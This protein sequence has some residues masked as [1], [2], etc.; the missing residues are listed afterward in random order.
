[1]EEKTVKY[2]FGILYS[3]P[4]NNIKLDIKNN[5][6]VVSY[7]NIS[8]IICNT[9]EVIIPD[10]A[11]KK[12]VAQLLL[13]HQ[14]VLEEIMQLGFTVLPMKLA[15]Y[16][17]SKDKI[18]ELLKNSYDF[19]NNL[20]KEVKDKI[21][22]DIIGSWADFPN[23]LKMIGENPKVIET[24]NRIISKKEGVT[25]ADQQEIG[26]LISKLVKNFNEEKANEC[27]KYLKPYC[28]QTK[29]HDVMNDQMIFNTAFLVEK[30]KINS[31]DNAI[32]EL[33]SKL[34]SSINF[35]YVGPL[36][37]YSFYTIELI[38]TNFEKILDS[39]NLLGIKD[40]ATMQD[41]KK[42]YRNKAILNHPDRKGNTT[43]QEFDEINKA[44]KYLLNIF[45]ALRYT[46]NTIEKI[47]FSKEQFDNKILLKL[48]E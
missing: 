19:L 2:L 25:L 7:K 5:I 17:E 31:F 6:E 39:K 30:Q 11:D 23:F 18:L 44:Y 28:C 8:A 15:T 13:H 22:I 24:K 32:D 26:F 46:N 20:E 34:K 4:Q 35:R 45:A 33:D 47:D 10:K 41:I 37:C 48:K 14:Q 40:T 29:P 3:L 1:M 9:D 21:E 27:N 43:A 12:K 38:E 36:P 42:A 16:L